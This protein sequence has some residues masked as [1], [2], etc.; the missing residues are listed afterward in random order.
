[1]KRLEIKEKNRFR[2]DEDEVREPSDTEIYPQQRKA[3]RS[4]SWSAI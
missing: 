3:V 1:M 4:A 2:R